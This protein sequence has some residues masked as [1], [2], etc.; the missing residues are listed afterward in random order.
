MRFTRDGNGRRI[1]QNLDQTSG[2]VARGETSYLL[3][4]SAFL[5]LEHNLVALGVLHL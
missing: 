5:K 1:K 3:Q 4:R 2:S